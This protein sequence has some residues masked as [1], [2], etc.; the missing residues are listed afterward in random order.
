MQNSLDF[1]QVTIFF[2]A[3]SS[4]KNDKFLSKCFAETMNRNLYTVSLGS[5]DYI[6]NAYAK[7]KL[8]VY[9]NVENL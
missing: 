5:K 7:G 8:A 4:I 6:N 2:E 3:K 1:S 9:A